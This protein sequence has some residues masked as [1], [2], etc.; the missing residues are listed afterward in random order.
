M[1]KN[2]NKN[3]QINKKIP[4]GHFKKQMFSF[5]LCF[6]WLIT[7]F[8][9]LF[10]DEHNE[11]HSQLSMYSF[12]TGVAFIFALVFKGKINTKFF[13]MTYDDEYNEK[14]KRIEGK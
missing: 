1:D 4:N 13:G 9:L 10:G 7:I 2:N 3:N 11:I 8:C 6:S 12:L 14:N 5:G